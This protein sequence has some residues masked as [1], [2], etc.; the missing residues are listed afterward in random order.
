MW[1][2]CFWS[3]GF[4]GRHG[5]GA[6][7]FSRRTRPV[8]GFERT[9]AG[10]W[11]GELAARGKAG[12][13]REAAHGLLDGV[14]TGDVA[15]H[16]LGDRRAGALVH[17]HEAPAHMAPAVREGPAA[18][19]PVELAQPVVAVMGVALQVS[20]AAAVEEALGMEALAA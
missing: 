12:V 20:P 2:S 16:G 4:N 18:L 6:F 5:L 9:D 3:H 8:D 14:E 7:G 13:G 19:G 15:D 1:E 10:G 11:G 17:F